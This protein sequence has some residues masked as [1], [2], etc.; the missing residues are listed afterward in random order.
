[1]TMKRRDLTILTLFVAIFIFT[2]CV[3]ENP[4]APDGGIGPGASSGNPPSS[5]EWLIP[6]NLVQEGGPGKDGIPALFGPTF[7]S[8][9]EATYLEDED[10]VLGLK[11][12]NDIRAYPHRILDWHEIIND[13]VGGLRLAITYC[14]L[15]GTGIGWNRDVEGEITSFGSSGLLYN[16]NLIPYDRESD[17]NWSQMLLKCVN[18][19]RAGT[20]IETTQL[21]ETTWATWKSIYPETRVVSRFTGYGRNYLLYPYGNYRTNHQSLFFPVAHEDN[22]LPWKER[23]LGVIINENAKAYRFGNFPETGIGVINDGFSGKSVVVV[24]SREKNF[25]VAFSGKRTDGQLLSFAPVNDALPIVMVDQE[26]NQWDIFGEAVSGP[27]AGERL[28]QV[29]AF[30]GYWVAWGAFYPHLRFR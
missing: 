24:G 14:P 9:E 29:D 22:R 10:M 11:V 4:K 19:E 2:Q 7:I 12:G 15:T 6:E 28:E 13:W 3:K 16:T 27:K 18:G 21:V 30:I 17:S 8:V 23:V 20:K 1:M 25:M 5:P 26:G